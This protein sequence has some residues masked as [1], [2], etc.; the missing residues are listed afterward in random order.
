MRF[1]EWSSGPARVL[2]LYRRRRRRGRQSVSLDGRSESCRSAGSA[3]SLRRRWTKASRPLER[4]R[5]KCAVD[6]GLRPVHQ[7][8]KYENPPAIGGEAGIHHRRSSACHPL[9]TIGTRTPGMLR[10]TSCLRRLISTPARSDWRSGPRPGVRPGG[11]R[12]NLAW[13]QVGSFSRWAHAEGAL[14]AVSA[15]WMGCYGH[16]AR[17]ISGW[18]ESTAK[19]LP[20]NWSS[21]S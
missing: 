21:S 8:S 9:V 13:A 4:D 5:A 6:C 16:E 20:K 7:A 2:L 11:G 19:S 3:R 18:S 14:V 15:T 10:P 1:R 12:A 17:E